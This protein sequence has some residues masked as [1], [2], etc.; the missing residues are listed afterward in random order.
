MIIKVTIITMITCNHCHPCDHCCVCLAPP[1]LTLG[2]GEAGWRPPCPGW[3]SLAPALIT[4]SQH[5]VNITIIIRPSCPQHSLSTMHVSLQ[6]RPV[7][8]EAGHGG[9]EALV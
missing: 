5:Y 4:L 8:V 6:T 2:R 3:P 1:G 7:P 9:G